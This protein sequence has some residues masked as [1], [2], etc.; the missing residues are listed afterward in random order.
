MV[1]DPVEDAAAWTT[2][3]E[4][5]DV[6]RSVRPL[7]FVRRAVESSDMEAIGSLLGRWHNREEHIKK[8]PDGGPNSNVIRGIGNCAFEECRARFDERR[9]ELENLGPLR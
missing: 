6:L 9:V 4:L 1:S 2:V 5:L 3:C 8:L 7:F